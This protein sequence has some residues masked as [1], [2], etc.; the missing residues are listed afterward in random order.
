MKNIAAVIGVLFV[1]LLAVMPALAVEYDLVIENGRVMDPETMY[2]AIA[3][4]GIKDGRIAAITKSKINGKE[5]ID[6]TG[7]IVSPGFID[8]HMHGLNIGAYRLQAVQGVT[9]AL[10]LESGVLPINDFYEGQAAKKLPIHYG[11]AAAWTFGRIAT[12]TDTE[13][14]ATAAYFQQAQGRTDW[15]EDLA[16]PE[17]LE[18]ILA[19]LEQGLKEGALGIG[20]NAGYAPGNGHFE[21]YSVAKLAKKYNVGTF[22]H[23]RFMKGPERDNAFEAFQGE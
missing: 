5:S 11:A 13:P 4:V 22:T 12:F 15:K 17:Q 18:R 9:T 7:K 10:E 1:S 14:E 21:Y 23:V 2:D 3:N 6:A 20:V 8:L 16:K 19:E